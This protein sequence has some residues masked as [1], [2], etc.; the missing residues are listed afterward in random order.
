MQSHQHFIRFVSIKTIYCQ[1][2]YYIFPFLYMNNCYVKNIQ[3]VKVLKAVY[4]KIMIV[5]LTPILF[6]EEKKNKETNVLAS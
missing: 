4:L 1:E 6:K 2:K 5:V 3:A